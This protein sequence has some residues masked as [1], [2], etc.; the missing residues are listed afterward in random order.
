LNIDPDRYF[1]FASNPKDPW[2]EC[3]RIQDKLDKEGPVDLC[4]LGIGLN[5]HLA[6]NEPSDYLSLG[7]HVTQLSETSLSHIMVDEMGKKPSFGLTLGMRDIL[8]SK[9]IL[10]IIQGVQKKDIIKRFLSK[11]V[12]NLLPASYLWLHPNVVCLIEKNA[13]EE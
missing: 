8:S 12:T 11:K 10:I 6:L 7:C 2:L 4:I 13:V 5:G 1:G 9:M 3:K